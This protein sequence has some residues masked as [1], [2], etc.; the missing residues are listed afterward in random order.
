MKKILLILYGL[1]I[2]MALG[3]I[4]KSVN[5]V[6]L[7]NLALTLAATPKPIIFYLYYT[8]CGLCGEEVEHTIDGKT[9][10]N[11]RTVACLPCEKLEKKI[12]RIKK[13]LQK[14]VIF[15]W[16]LLMWVRRLPSDPF[17]RAHRSYIIA[18]SK[19]SSFSK[20]QILIADKNI[21]L[22]EAY[23]EKVLARIS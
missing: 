14:H 20:S 16:S 9:V 1:S 11:L 19:I 5:W 10:K 8:E 23:R 13:C 7:E 17:I 4:P 18:V 2:S 15:T 6:P 22:G 21:P 12:W 3:Q